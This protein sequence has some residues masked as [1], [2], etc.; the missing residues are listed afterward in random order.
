[1]DNMLYI[2]YDVIKGVPHGKYIKKRG[3]LPF[4]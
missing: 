4:I 2:N 3:N 1:M